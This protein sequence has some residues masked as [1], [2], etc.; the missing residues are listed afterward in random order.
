MTKVAYA[1]KWLKL[2]R[3]TMSYLY[4]SMCMRTKYCHNVSYDIPTRSISGWN[5][6]ELFETF[7]IPT[8]WLF[9]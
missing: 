6:Y 1:L 9:E 4:S 8:C 5:V 7:S 2:V 3:I